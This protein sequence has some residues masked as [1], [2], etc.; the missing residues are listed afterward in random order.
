MGAKEAIDTFNCNELCSLF[1][2]KCRSSLD[3][4]WEIVKLEQISY[5]IFSIIFKFLMLCYRF[6]LE[7][8]KQVKISGKKKQKKERNTHTHA[9][10]HTTN[11]PYPPV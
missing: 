3:L 5:V 10:T 11:T 7:H 6:Q 2:G 8:Y 9:C 4:N 1:R